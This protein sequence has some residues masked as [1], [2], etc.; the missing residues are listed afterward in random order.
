MVVEGDQRDAQPTTPGPA[1]TPRPRRRRALGIGVGLLVA[2]VVAGLIASG[3]IRLD[4]RG[5]GQPVRIAVVEANGALRTLNADGSDRRVHNVESLVFQFPAWSPDGRHL[6]AIGHDGS[7]SGVF[8]F[9]DRAAR[10]AATTA[11]PVAAY[12]SRSAA[13]IYLYWSPDGRRIAFLTGEPDGLALQV[14]AADGSAP[15]AVVRRG[16]P[17][18]WDWIDSSHVFVHSGASAPGA[19]LG[20]VAVDTSDAQAIEASVGSFQAPAMSLDGRARAYVAGEGE[21]TT[22]VVEARDGSFRHE[23]RVS[24]GSALGWSPA[25][26]Q[27]A[28]SNSP[29]AIGLPVGPLELIDVRSGTT[30][31]LVDGPVIAWFW[32]PDGRTLAVLR[33]RIP[34]DGQVAA[35]GGRLQAT[36]DRLA[37]RLL[38]VDVA[39]GTVGFGREVR[40]SDLVLAQFLPFADQY[41][42]SHR[43]WSPAS[44][45]IVLPIQ[46]ETGSSHI[47]IVPADGSPERRIAD[48]VAAFWS[49]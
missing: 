16:Q 5:P 25:G 1:P 6:A 29:L 12:R 17:L 38:F 39:T 22:V 49:P 19:F 28:Y 43:I 31:Q 10:D 34:G 32:A 36:T 8:V 4:G 35:A 47:T 15:A 26:D 20:E 23:V 7:D 14:A 13:P 45:A 46:D 11:Q 21:S 44:D 48:G 33:F 30:R 41:A 3:A 9:D 27:L 40:L 42:R 37:L 18:Y 24:A 2:I